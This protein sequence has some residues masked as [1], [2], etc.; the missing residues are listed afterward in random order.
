MKTFLVLVLTVTA[1]FLWQRNASQNAATGASSRSE[2]KVTA[3][4]SSS[5]PVSNGDWMKHSLD[6]AHE[7]AGQ[8]QA[9]RNQGDQP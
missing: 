1:L 2:A 4:A 5:Q 9:A 3:P 6:R 8:V 7:V